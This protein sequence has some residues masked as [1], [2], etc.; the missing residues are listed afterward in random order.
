MGHDPGNLVCRGQI[1]TWFWNNSTW[2]PAW[3][4][5]TLKLWS[6]SETSSLPTVSVSIAQKRQ[7]KDTSQQG[8]FDHPLVVQ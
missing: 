8:A 4:F 6:D 1:F 5:I 3:F 7:P 2:Q